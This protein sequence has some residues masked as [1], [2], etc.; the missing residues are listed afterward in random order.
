[1][2]EGWSSDPGLW[3][4]DFEIEEGKV[5]LKPS[6]D[7]ESFET[8]SAEEMI[9]FDIVEGNKLAFDAEASS[10]GV[11]YELVLVGPGESAPDINGMLFEPD[12]KESLGYNFGFER[13]E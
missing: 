12:A 5:I 6:P 4:G 13:F 9:V 1:M 8:D 7:K 2:L 10:D 11:E 3:S